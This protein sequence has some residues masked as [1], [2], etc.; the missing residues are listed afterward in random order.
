[1]NKHSSIN[2]LEF[3]GDKT[4]LH[5]LKTLLGFAVIGSLHLSSWAQ[6]DWPKAKPVTL[7][8]AFAAGS[9]T[10]IVARSLTQKLN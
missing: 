5:Y 4:M 6:S 3:K 9:S 8:V 10:D 7:V 2:W 1:V